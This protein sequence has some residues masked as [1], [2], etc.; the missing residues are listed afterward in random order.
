M[1]RIHL[2]DGYETLSVYYLDTLEECQAVEEAYNL[3][4]C[5]HYHLRYFET[6]KRGV[7]A[8]A[9]IEDLIRWYPKGEEE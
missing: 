3:Y 1:Y 7:G 2:S 9:V 8:E 5:G 4:G 6:P